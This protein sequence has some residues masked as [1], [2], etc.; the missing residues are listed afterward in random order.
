[1]LSWELTEI[2]HPMGLAWCLA[3]SKLPNGHTLKINW[4]VG[5]ICKVLKVFTPYQVRSKKSF[6]VRYQN[7][8]LPSYTPPHTGCY[9]LWIHSN[10]E[11]SVYMPLSSTAKQRRARQNQ[12]QKL[13]SCLLAFF[14]LFISVT[15]THVVPKLLRNWQWCKVR[16]WLWFGTKQSPG[17]PH[18]ACPMFP[19]QQ[20]KNQPAV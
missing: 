18:A 6:A 17:L 10:L 19:H 2:M 4:D 1:M 14:S 13:Y 11:V 15:S 20:G 3:L 7:P 8:S 16:H 9:K 12:R 5:F